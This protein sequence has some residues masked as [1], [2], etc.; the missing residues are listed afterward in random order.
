MVPF[1]DLH[2]H[3]KA[4]TPQEVIAVQNKFLQDL[5]PDI[6]SLF[7]SGL[8]PWHVDNFDIPDIERKLIEAIAQKGIVAIGETGLDKKCN[9]SFGKQLEVFRLH[10]EMANNANLPMVIHCVGA[11]QEIIAETKNLLS[12]KIIHGYAGNIDLTQQLFRQNF[13]FSIGE[14]ILHAKSKVKASVAW[15]PT[16][17]LFCETDER[18]VDICEIYREVA[19]QKKITIGQLKN[20][21]LLNFKRLNSNKKDWGEKYFVLKNSIS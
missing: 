6:D 19:L 18:S 10:I 1:I 14:P 3:K 9:A 12:P 20:D 8:H 15:L 21:I 2:C 17:A 7:T 4:T 11:W 5:T 16:S 13:L